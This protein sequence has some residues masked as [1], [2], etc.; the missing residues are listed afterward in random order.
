MY[1][2]RLG[3]PV[4]GEPGA[5]HAGRAV[6]GGGGG[7]RGSGQ[8]QVPGGHPQHLEQ[9]RLRHRR[10]RSHQGHLQEGSQSCFVNSHRI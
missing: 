8:R 9:D 4:L 1:I 5:G 7:V 10:H 3:V 6:H 2:C